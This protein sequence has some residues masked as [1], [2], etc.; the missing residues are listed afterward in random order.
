MGADLVDQSD[1]TAGEAIDLI[2]ST[3]RENSIGG[4]GIGKVPRSVGGWDVV[5][6]T[7]V[8]TSCG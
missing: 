2:D 7:K 3:I 1:Y 8:M 6:S 5:G 4:T